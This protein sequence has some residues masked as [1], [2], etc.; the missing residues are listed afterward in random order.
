MG[1]HLTRSGRDYRSEE[2]VGVLRQALS[3]VKCPT[4]PTR[5]VDSLTFLHILGLALGADLGCVPGGIVGD[6]ALSMGFSKDKRSCWY[7]P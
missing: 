3:L 6:I 1:L 7:W 4:P 2:R 5:P